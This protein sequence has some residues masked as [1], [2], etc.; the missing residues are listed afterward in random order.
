MRIIVAGVPGAGKTTIMEEVSRRVNY[1]IVN[2]GDIMLQMALE[3]NFVKHRDEMRK[4]PI[5]LQRKLQSE[6]ARKIGSMEKVIIDTHLTIKT[7]SGYFPGLPR[8]VLDEINP[9]LIVIV[10]AEPHEIIRR[11]KKDTSRKRDYETSEEIEEHIQANRYAGF[12]CSILTGAPIMILQNRD[13]M[14]D[15]AVKKFMEAFK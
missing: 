6:A 12:A 2:Y 3:K 10:E 4:L 13:G 1:K 7:P 8:W 11:R 15:V 5:E 9:N 14:L